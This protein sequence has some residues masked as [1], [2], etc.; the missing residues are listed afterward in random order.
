MSATAAIVLNDGTSDITFA[1]SGRSGNVSRFYNAGNTPI[2]DETL[3]MNLKQPTAQ[4]STTITEAFVRVPLEYQDTDTGLYHV[5][6]I[7]L[8]KVQVVIP[9]S[10]TE[11]D[12]TRLLNYVKNLVAHTVFSEHVVDREPIY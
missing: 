12:R 5:D 1:P 4:R 6:D 2:G 10:M 11:A 7:A 9:A 8:A 3:Q